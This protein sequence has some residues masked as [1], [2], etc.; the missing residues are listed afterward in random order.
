MKKNIIRYVLISMFSGAILTACNDDFLNTQP[1]DK[2][3][4]ELVWSDAALAESFVTDLYNGLNA[5]MLDQ[6]NMETITDNA[7]YNFGKQDIME[8][9]VSPANVGWV[10]GNYEWS[11]M[12]RRIRAANIALQNLAS[13]KFDNAGTVSA[14]RLKGEAYFMRAYYYNQMLRWYGAIPIVKKPY[15][16]NNPDFTIARNTYEEC[17]D[18]IVSDLD[19]AALLLQGKTLAAGRATQG[20]ALALKARVLTYAASDLHDIPTASAK[21]PV[22]AG[23]PNKEQ[24]G[25]IS[26]DQTARWQKARDAA[27]A[28]MDLNIYGYKLDESLNAPVTPEEGQQNYINMYLS[29]GGGEREAIFSRYFLNTKDEWGAWYPRNNMP[30]GYHGWTSSEPTQNLVDDYEMMDGTKF[31]WKK[32]EHA[33]APYQNRD[34]R[35]YATVLYDGAQWKPR[36]SDGKGID[37]Y[38]QIQMGTYQI[39]SASNP[40]TYFG[41]DTRNSSI[42]NWNGTRTGYAIRKFI[43]I[44]PGIEDQ[45]TRQEV[46]SPQIRFT[47][48]VFNYIEASLELGD[49]A[50]ALKWLNRIRFRVG[51]PAV[52]ES[53][54]A[55]VER[56]RNERNVEM[57]FEEQR[58][59]DTRRWMIAPDVLGEKV[60]IVKITG[61]LKPG[62]TVQ[63]YK[64][65]PENYT[66]TYTVQDIDPGVENRR[67]DDKM[68]FMPIHRDEM[69]RNNKLVQ[70][71]GYQ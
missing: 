44:D 21:S 47:E 15:D 62:K 33:A 41:L 63:V 51:M 5:G 35:F 42:E 13:P 31:D 57:T 22:I 39:G 45:N 7:L 20:A 16:L 14:D 66:Y 10:S 49:E 18:F 23:A 26:G 30:N 32:P 48:V 6:Q 9:N 43:N 27:K 19:S 1:L 17:V 64:Y 69:N 59:Y 37:P 8:A 68:Y 46:P 34:P 71:P 25:Y 12:Y 56:Y 4:G 50:E 70:N 2:A 52:N 60:K 3:T 36:T 54:A 58:F 67:W 65:D 11:A 24:L 55:L 38:G 28:V 40:T 29:R 61:T 53:G